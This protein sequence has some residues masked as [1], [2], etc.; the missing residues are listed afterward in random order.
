MD[1]VKNPATRTVTFSKNGVIIQ[2]L[3][4]SV[5][6]TLNDKRNGVILR[7]TT[8]REIQVYT[9]SIENTQILPSPPLKFQP[10]TTVDLWDRLFDPS[11]G[12][13]D[14]LHIKFSSGG[15]G[16]LKTKSGLV[17]GGS[18]AGF[19]LSAAVVFAAPF[20]S[21]QYAVNVTGE[22]LRLW[23]ISGKS[24]AG[25]TIQSNSIVPIAGN[26]FWECIFQGES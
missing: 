24:A 9:T 2:T 23:S 25:F 22:N 20:A 6:A 11:V 19:P 26:V 7:D 4:E 5:T 12:F 15:G 8:G 17:A 21:N 16:G 14:E 13:F 1:I 18:F 10:G 3:N